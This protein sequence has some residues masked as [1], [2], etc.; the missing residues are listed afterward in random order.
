MPFTRRQILVT[1]A[2]VPLAAC[3]GTATP[4][5]AQIATD[6]NLVLNS[7][8][9]VVPSVLAASGVPAA[10]AATITQD[11]ATAK[12]SVAA[13]AALVDGQPVPTAT[14]KQFVLAVN[15]IFTLASTPPLSALIPPQYEVPIAAVGALLP[16]LE[17]EAGISLSSVAATAPK[18]T[19]D[20]ARLILRAA[21][22]TK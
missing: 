5:P 8:T 17:A 16:I 9:A 18:Y 7:L 13:L 1:T 4:S 3:S 11:L 20:N 12:V 14:A 19:P 21:A 15:D 22:V 6:V 2:L 10:T